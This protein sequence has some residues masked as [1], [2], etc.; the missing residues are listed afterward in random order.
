MRHF[1]KEKADAILRNRIGAKELTLQYPEYKE[2]VMKEFSELGE[3]SGDEEVTGIIDKY[4]ASAR[5]AINRIQTSGENSRTVDSFLPEIIK[6]RIAVYILEQMSL[7]LQTHKS[8]GRIRFKLWD[9]FILQKILFEKDLQRKPASI[10][11]F[12]FFWPLII[13]KRILMPLVNKK[14]I[15]CFYSA[16]LLLELAQLIGQS[17][18][19]EIGAG[20]GTLTRFLT[21]FG[22]NCRATDDYSWE[23]FIQYPA[24]VEKIDARQ[25][26]QKYKPHTVICSWPPPGNP[27]EKQI[28]GA[29]SVNLYIMIGTKSAIYSGDQ[30]LYD[31]Q[32]K[33][34]VTYSKKLSQLLLPPSD[35]NAVYIFRR[36]GG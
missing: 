34:T 28:L 18:C 5:L 36:T 35:E 24:A 32:D 22:V 19:L 14:G 27:F 23:N 13:D 16:K 3:N 30:N 9:G 20:D 15:Y 25:A 8:S 7:S 2:A 26:L 10:F 31:N 12:K 4:K 6:A 29:S 1:T 33:F 11:W 21:G 17:D